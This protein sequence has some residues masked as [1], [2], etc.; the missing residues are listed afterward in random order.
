[1]SDEKGT[2]LRITSGQVMQMN[3]DF[4][5]ADVVLA[6]GLVERIGDGT[7]GRKAEINA[8]GMLVLPGIVDLHGDAFE[9]QIMPRPGVSF[10]LELAL[11]YT[12]RQMVASSITTVYHGV[13]YSWEPS[14]R[15]PPTP[16]RR[17]DALA[18]Q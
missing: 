17:V 11:N 9:R 15:F 10:P 14:F 5:G 2:S 16:L 3:G 18:T 13:T 4:V 6:D 7:G 1:M 12:D 8:S